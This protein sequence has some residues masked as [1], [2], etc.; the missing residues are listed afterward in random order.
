MFVKI[1]Q[2]STF[3]ATVNDQIIYQQKERV[4]CPEKK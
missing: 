1:Q 4:S 2:E 3:F